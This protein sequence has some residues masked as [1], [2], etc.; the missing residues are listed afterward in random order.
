MV[1]RGANATEKSSEERLMQKYNRLRLVSWI[2]IPILALALGL[3]VYLNFNYLVFKVL[4][5]EHYAYDETLADLYASELGEDTQGSYMARFDDFVIAAVTEKIR[6]KN[7]DYY[8]YLY[9]PPS[10]VLQKEV[11]Q[12]VAVE[13]SFIKEIRADT[14]YVRIPNFSSYTESFLHDN[15]EEVSAYPYVVIDLRGNGGGSLDALYEM[16]DLF[17]DKNMLIGKEVARTGFFSK[18]IKAKSARYFDFEGIYLLQDGQ[19]ASASE[20]FIN[21]LRENLDN[22]TVVGTQSYGKGIGQVTIPLKDGYAVKATTMIL[23]TPNGNCIHRVGIAPDVV[24]ED[25]DIVEFVTK[26]IGQ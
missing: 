4:I 7:Q 25:D 23:E 5:T 22:V 19:T 6:T 1:L 20:S 2:T 17:L 18:T 14:V 24:Y 8:T 26:Q 13:G 3:M 11:V 10:Y 16:A 12:A 15:R 9:T 21:A